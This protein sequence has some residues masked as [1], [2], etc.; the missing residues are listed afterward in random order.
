M[1]PTPTDTVEPS[2]GAVAAP[3]TGTS[4]LAARE[5]RLAEAGVLLVVICWA[6][7]FVVVKA[8]LGDLPPLVFTSLRYVVAA[9]T[10]LGLLRV[11]E[12]NVGLPRRDLLIIAALG[13]LGFGV[14]QLLWTV[15]LTQINAGDSALLIAT[16]PVLVAL[17]AAMVGTD[18]LTPPKLAGALVSFAGVALVV[19]AGQDFTLGASM[20]G[21]AVTLCAAVAW[22]I[23]TA[24]AARALRRADPLRMTAWA[25]TGGML[26][27]LP[28]GAW[29]AATTPGLTIEPRHVL[30]MLYSGILA[31]GLANVLILRG[32]KILG[33]TRVT[34]LQYGVS[35]L[36]VILGALFLGETIRPAQIFG[37]V[38]IVLGVVIT[39][40]RRGGGSF[41]LQRRRTV[42]I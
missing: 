18:T 30:A 12:G 29:Q 5:R 25:V 20:A 24:L 13:V 16:T 35:P 42:A 19:G 7:N 41:R 21:D 36:A 22:A 31:A 14:Y 2:A 26:F 27:L 39:R 37:G 34:V 38:V 1:P 3:R 33:P 4:A 32:V 28:L 15:G 10:V 17:I 9:A 11:R 23:Y 8:A 40:A 6:A